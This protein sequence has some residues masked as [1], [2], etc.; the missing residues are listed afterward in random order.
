MHQLQI[1]MLAISTQMKL[2][3]WLLTGQ[4]YA[5]QAC[6]SE[7]ERPMKKVSKKLTRIHGLARKIA[8]ILNVLRTIVDTIIYLVS[9]VTNY[10]APDVPRAV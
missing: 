2:C 9:L 5:C 4:I 1:G 7:G 6:R 8:S 10:D 3:S